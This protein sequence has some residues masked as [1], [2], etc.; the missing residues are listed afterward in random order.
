MRKVFPRKQFWLT[1]MFFAVGISLAVIVSC[2]L[3]TFGGGPNADYSKV[4]HAPSYPGVAT[5]AAPMVIDTNVS[6]DASTVVR[7][8]PDDLFGNNIAAW[9]GSTDGKDAFLNDFMKISGM[10]LIRYPGG[11]W[12]DIVAWDTVGVPSSNSWELDNNESIAFAKAAGANLQAIVNFSGYWD[13]VQH[14]PA[15]AVAK[16][17]NWVAYMKN[18]AAFPIKYWE[19][20]NESYGSWEQGYTNG[21]AYGSRFADFYKAMKAIDSTIQIGAVSTPYDNGDSYTGYYWWMRD[22]LSNSIAKGVIPDYLIIHTY[23]M[24]EAMSADADARLLQAPWTISQLTANLD[25]I[26]ANYAGSSYVGKIP[27]RMTEYRSVLNSRGQTITFLDAMFTAQYIME[28]AKHGWAGANLWNIRNGMSTSYNG[29]YGIFQKTS[30]GT[31]I[32]DYYTTYL[33]FPFLSSKFGRS[34]VNASVTSNSYINAYAAKDASGNLTIL[35]INNSPDTDLTAQVNITGFTAATN[36]L[37]WVLAPAGMTASGATT[38]IQECTNISYNGVV[39]P[40]A[41]TAYYTSGIPIKTGTNFPVPVKKSTMVLVN[42]PSTAN[43]SSSSSVSSMSFASSS[44]R[45]SDI[46]QTIPGK[47]IG[48]YYTNM[49]GIQVESCGDSNGV[50]DGYDIGYI[51]YGDWCDYNVNVQSTANYNVEFRIAGATPAGCIQIYTNGQWI[52]QTISTLPATTGYQDWTSYNTN[53]T[54]TAGRYVLRVFFNGNGF[55]F[56]YAN[57]T[58]PGGSS[59]SSSAASSVPASSSRSSVASSVASSIASSTA[60]SSSRAASSVASS[61]AVSSSRSSAASSAAVS[62]SRSSAA[63]SVAVSS[64]RAASSAVSSAA[65][66]SAASSTAASS[67]GYA[68]NY[69]VNNDWGAGATCTVTIKNNS[70]AALSSWSLVWTFAGNQ[71]ITQIWSASQTTSGETVT[72][73]N[74]SYNGAIGANGGTQSFGFNLSYSGSNAKPTAFTLNGTACSIY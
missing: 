26:V 23:P 50:G 6:V 52:M 73:V 64:S 43:A 39:H 49:N 10:K 21:A 24:D 3:S 38:P 28:M 7:T 71:A 32:D 29:D 44:S 70:A 55:N 13:G 42:V 22:M 58:I 51:D 2:S 57:F 31:V 66:S 65:V 12:A 61:V 60:V 48:D 16:A 9:E 56:E 37:E 36:G 33:V 41:Q 35:L 62:S 47:V 19:I 14:T 69:T 8:M 11:S 67:G 45:P 34:M 4:N 1:L 63:S 74:L 68:V 5:R 72:A 27:Y 59:S 17:S 46:V 15:D 25:Q 54:L 53:F 20:G 30:S 40:S 18:T